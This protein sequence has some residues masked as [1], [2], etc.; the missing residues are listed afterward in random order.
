MPSP[1]VEGTTYY[2]IP[3]TSNTFQVAASISGSALN[4]TTAGSN[5][6]VIPEMP[7]TAWIDEC[8]AM[9]DQTLPAHAVPMTVV[10]ECV[11]LYCAVLLA[12][13]ALAHVGAQTAAVQG[14]LEYW[15]KQAEKWGKGQ[16]IRGT[17]APAC[18][19]VAVVN[20]Y[21]ADARGWSTDGRLP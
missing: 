18:V 2:A 6:L 13:R 11:R 20:P 7:W 21:T 12:M 5:L 14:Q 10:P 15:T 16:I 4:I 3:L 9:V 8:S 1:M 19:N 17:N